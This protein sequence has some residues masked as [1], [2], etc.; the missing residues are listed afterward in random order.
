MVSHT[1]GRHMRIH[2]M[3]DERDGVSSESIGRVQMLRHCRTTIEN[4]LKVCSHAKLHGGPPI[5]R[6]AVAPLRRRLGIECATSE[7]DCAA[8][9]ARRRCAAKSEGRMSRCCAHV[10]ARAQPWRSDCTAQR[11]SARPLAGAVC[12]V[13]RSRPDGV[14]AI[15]GRDGYTAVQGASVPPPVGPVGHRR[16]W[17]WPLSSPHLTLWH[18]RKRARATGLVAHHLRAQLTCRHT[19]AHSST[20]HCSPAHRLCVVARSV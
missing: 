9:S 14:P 2:P 18:P 5:D 7:P 12:G 3:N 13:A 4:E 11:S 17:S 1:T 6:R 19:G 16:A 10:A 15:R 20:L 8:S